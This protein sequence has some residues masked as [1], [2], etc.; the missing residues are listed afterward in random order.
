MTVTEALREALLTSNDCTCANDR[1]YKGDRFPIDL[2]VKDP[3][4]PD[5]GDH[6]A[7]VLPSLDD[8]TADAWEPF[9]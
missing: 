6:A 9:A 1:I 5:H 2:R 4:C 7:R 8:I 3:D